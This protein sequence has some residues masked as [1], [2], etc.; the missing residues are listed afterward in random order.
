ML[1]QTRINHP[2]CQSEL[3]GAQYDWHMKGTPD[4]DETVDNNH[5]SKV[6]GLATCFVLY[7]GVSKAYKYHISIV[8]V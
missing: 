1:T 6:L 2:L 5:V 8:S 7:S 4:R 3:S